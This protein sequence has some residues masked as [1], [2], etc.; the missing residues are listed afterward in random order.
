MSEILHFII[1]HK[2]FSALMLVSNLIIARTALI[3]LSV[4][5][6]RNLFE[7]SGGRNERKTFYRKIVYIVRNSADEYERRY[8]K[9][10]FYIR[11]RDKITKSGYRGEYAAVI[12]IIFKY[13]CPVFIFLFILAVNFPDTR[14]SLILAL[15]TYIMVEYT[16]YKKKRKLTLTFSRYIYKIYKY[17]HNQISSGIKPTDAIKTVY[18]TIDDK[19][20]RSILVKLAAR[21][22]LTLD[23]DEALREFQSNFDIQE[24]ETLCVA[25]K[26]GIQTGDNQELL[27]RQEQFMFNKYFNYIQAETDS[28]R[29]RGTVS[30]LIFASITVIMIAVPLFK[31]VIEAAGKIFVN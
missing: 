22:E 28:C 18:L 6:N 9:T 14:Y 29:L 1:N 4:Y 19:E 30:V 11:A 20:L 24:A 2:Y 21:Y 5:L 3:K 7:A 23:I 17:L 8:K 15:F 25:L 27:A 10:G 16:V 26:Q 31:D 12:Y 13:A